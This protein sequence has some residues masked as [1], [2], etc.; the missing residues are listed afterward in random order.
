VSQVTNGK[1]KR[2]LAALLAVGAFAIAVPAQ[3]FA[4][5]HGSAIT[6]EPGDG[7]H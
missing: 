1:L 5:S 3:S 7:G 2:T 6:S 4:G